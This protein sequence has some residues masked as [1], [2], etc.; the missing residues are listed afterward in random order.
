MVRQ[1]INHGSEDDGNDNRDSGTYSLAFLAAR[2]L[3]C[4]F[5]SALGTPSNLISWERVLDAKTEFLP[6]AKDAVERR[7]LDLGP[8]AID[9][10]LTDARLLLLEPGRVLWPRASLFF[11]LFFELESISF[12]FSSGIA[13]GSVLEPSS[14]PIIFCGVAP[15]LSP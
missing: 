10:L 13:V 7:F 3:A 12:P 8:N 1:E 15:F 11:G 6:P 14:A 2:S 9:F 5:I 4:R